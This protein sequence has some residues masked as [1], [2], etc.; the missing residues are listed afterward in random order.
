MNTFKETKE[1]SIGFIQ[2]TCVCVCV[3]ALKLELTDVSMQ[4]CS[5]EPVPSTYFP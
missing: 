3:C 5:T 1:S 4:H 2:H